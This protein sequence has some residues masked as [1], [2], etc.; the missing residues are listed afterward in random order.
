MGTIL[1]LVAD[2]EFVLGL[3]VAFSDE[4]WA[5]KELMEGGLL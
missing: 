1:L 3:E 5:W 2:G 4:K